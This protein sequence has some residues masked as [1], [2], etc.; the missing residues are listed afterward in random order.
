M[1]TKIML[2]ALGLVA[3][4]GGRL[5]GDGGNGG[6]AAD[7]REL[8]KNPSL[9]VS[10]SLNADE[11]T[12]YGVRLGDSPDKIGVDAGVTPSGVPERSQDTIYT[13]R[14]VRYYANDGRIYRITIMGDLA[15]G[16]PTYDATRLQVAMG[17]AD[18]ILENASSED[19]RLSFFAKHV[20]YTVHAYR[21]ISLVSEVD[22]YE[23]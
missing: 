4:L 9:L 22:L 11:L 3:V 18:E 15:R 2:A 20:R 21:S 12:V 17:K 1:K 23:P 13:G 10:P 6:G 5:L 7:G 14:N 8:T 16:L 19:T